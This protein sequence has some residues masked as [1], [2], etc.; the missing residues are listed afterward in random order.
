MAI[1]EYTLTP[2]DGATLVEIAIPG[3]GVL[4]FADLPAIL[5][6][7][8]PVT[9]HLGVILSGRLPIPA[10]CAIAHHLHPTAWVAIMA[11][12]AGGA[13]VVQSHKKGFAVGQVVSVPKS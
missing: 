10:Y 11:P 9:P 6:E 1:L 4:D 12:A 7:F 3:D 5:A 8:P 13:V 2:L